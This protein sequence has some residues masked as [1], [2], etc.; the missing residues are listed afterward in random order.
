MLQRESPT[1]SQ[2]LDAA[3]RLFY[4]VGIHTVGIDRIIAEAG[5][6]PGVGVDRTDLAFLAHSPTGV[7]RASPCRGREE[8]ITTMLV[9]NPRR[10][11]SAGA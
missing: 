7:A 6:P 4:T 10:F 2:I 5:F 1:R 3:R 9:D 8:Q 11:L